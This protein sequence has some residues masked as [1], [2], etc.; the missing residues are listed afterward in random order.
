MRNM[1]LGNRGLDVLCTGV[2]SGTSPL[3]YLNVAKNELSALGMIKFTDTVYLLKKLEKLDLSENPIGSVGMEE[4][5]K[6]ISRR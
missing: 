3:T 2:E 6:V 4:F 1:Q 5:S